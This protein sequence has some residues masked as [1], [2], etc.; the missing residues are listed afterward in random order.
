MHC[1]LLV[2]L[3]D[4]LVNKGSL[5]KVDTV[6]KFTTENKVL[7][8]LLNSMKMS[9][10][11]ALYLKQ[12]TKSNFITWKWISQFPKPL[13]NWRNFRLLIWVV[14]KYCIRPSLG[15]VIP[16]KF[17]RRCVQQCFG[18]KINW[19]TTRLQFNGVSN[20]IYDVLNLVIFRKRHALIFYCPTR[21]VRSIT[22]VVTVANYT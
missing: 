3:K 11:V 5:T 15:V 12:L 4:K 22:I 6:E 7:R 2:Q 8:G 16:F 18:N 10:C 20:V 9:T 1:D 17:I 21:A 13:E 14:T 19:K